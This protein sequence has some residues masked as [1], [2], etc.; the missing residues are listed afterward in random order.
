[1]DNEYIYLPKTSGYAAV[2]AV[3]ISEPTTQVKG[4]VSTISG[5]S[6]FVTSFARMI[7]NSNAEVNG[8]K[9]VLLVCILTETNSD[10]NK[11]VVYA[12]TNG[13]EAAPVTLAAFCWD[14]ANNVNDWRRYGDRFF[15]SGSWDEG[16]LYFPSFNAGKIV[17]LDVANGARTAVEQYTATTNSPEG[18]KDLCI[19]PGDSKLFITNGSVANLVATDGT[20]TNGWDTLV[21]DSS[22]DNGK[23]TWGYNFFKFNGK[24]W[25]A[26]ARIDGNKAWYEIIEDKGDL[27]SS[28][29]AQEGLI[30][31]PIHNITNLDAEHAT[32]GV[33]DCCVR[34]INGEVVIA[35]MTRDGG[36]VVDKLVFE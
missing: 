34:V 9:D 11:L 36:L 19:Y 33:A 20:K 2:G 26:Y 21:L 35:A 8:G 14:S 32:G 5:G 18:I 22:S 7:K 16:K 30:K 29:N 13:V 1:M 4:N 17:V 25:I 12:Y 15:V 28:L 24:D 3:K 6:T 10:A 27:I 23:G 31:G